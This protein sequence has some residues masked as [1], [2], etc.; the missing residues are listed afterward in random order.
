MLIYKLRIYLYILSLCFNS[1][2]N[3]TCNI[4]SYDGVSF[5]LFSIIW[6]NFK[7]NIKLQQRYT[8]NSTIPDS[9]SLSSPVACASPREDVEGPPMPANVAAL[10]EEHRSYLLGRLPGQ[11]TR[12][13][14]A[15]VIYVCA[16]DSQ[17]RFEILGSKIFIERQ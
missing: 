7:I 10:P 17:G 12:R 13:R 6:K 2:L 9:I 5:Y 4:I 14:R 1:G 3:K 11:R 15:M 8:L 16:A